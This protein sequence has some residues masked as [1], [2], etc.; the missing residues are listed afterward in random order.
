MLGIRVMNVG[1]ALKPGGQSV[2]HRLLSLIASTERL[3]SSWHLQDAVI[4]EETHD[5]IEIVRV[6]G[7]A[8]TNELRPDVGH[9]SSP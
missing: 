5:P 7:L 3:G 4:G 6:E 1:Q 8:Q 9:V 2:A